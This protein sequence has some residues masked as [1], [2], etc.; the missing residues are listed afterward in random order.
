MTTPAISGREFLE[1]G[2][3]YTKSDVYSAQWAPESIQFNCT[4]CKER[5]TWNKQVDVFPAGDV[6]KTPRFLCYLCS[7]CR[8]EKIFFLVLSEVLQPEPRRVLAPAIMPVMSSASAPLQ[9]PIVMLTKVGQTP[10]PSIAIPREV[11]EAF[12]EQSELYKRALICR[13]QGYGVAAVAYLRRIVE[14]HTNEL[15]EIAADLS[16]STGAPAAQV[17]KIR[18]AKNEKRYQ[19][20]LKV[21]SDQ[22]PEALRPG[23]ANPLGILHDT[24][25]RD[26]HGQPEEVC[27]MTSETIREAFEY[28]FVKLRSQ[29]REQQHFAKTIQGLSTE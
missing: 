9:V 11:E 13:N 6:A 18:A 25:S 12:G 24:L 17:E 3:L 2:A 23:G 21:A 5:S 28:L 10:T 15:I 1:R 22:V 7:L 8:T 19:D 4:R 16:Q 29:I 27:L 14:D 26:L 20:K